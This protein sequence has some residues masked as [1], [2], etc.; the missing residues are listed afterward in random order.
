VAVLV[1]LEAA[2]QAVLAQLIVL[3]EHQQLTVS[4]EVQALGLLQTQGMVETQTAPTLQG[5][6]AL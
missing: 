3:L 2:Q 4:V 6:L 1:V 5:N